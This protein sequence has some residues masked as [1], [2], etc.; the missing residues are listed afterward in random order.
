MEV[1]EESPLVLVGLGPVHAGEPPMVGAVRRGD[2]R[3][4]VVLSNVLIRDVDVGGAPSK[5]DAAAHANRGKE[6]ESVVGP[7][8]S[9]T[10]KE[11]MSSILVS[12]RH[13]IQGETVEITLRTA[14]RLAEELRPRTFQNN[15]LRL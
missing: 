8:V 4:N 10:T 11:E 1:R 13:T 2:E 5:K 7:R 3:G 15:A 6:S 9:K 14:V 12:C